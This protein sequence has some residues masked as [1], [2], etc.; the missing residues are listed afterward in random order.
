MGT[1]RLRIAEDIV[2]RNSFLGAEEGISI[3]RY[4]HSLD[5]GEKLIT[6]RANLNKRKKI[7]G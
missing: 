6:Q 1:K 5:E 2:E 7:G 4:N 3:T